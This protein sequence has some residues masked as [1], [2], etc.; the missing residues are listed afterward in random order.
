MDF[1]ICHTLKKEL[2]ISRLFRG[3]NGNN[4][5]FS[6]NCSNVFYFYHTL[7]CMFLTCPNAK[8]EK[9]NM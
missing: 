6:Q 3:I 5:S 8:G 4:N 1:M 7:L 9:E 2:L